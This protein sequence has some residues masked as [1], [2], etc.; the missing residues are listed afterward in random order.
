MSSPSKS[1]SN[2]ITT[3]GSKYVPPHL[4]KTQ[5]SGASNTN[6][7]NSNPEEA[8]PSYSRNYS[9]SSSFGSG[10]GGN[11]GG[12]GYDRN[13]QDNRSSI[14]SN[15]TAS[16]RWN[17]DAPDHTRSNGAPPT[18]SFS[19][20]RG[21]SNAAHTNARGFHGDMSPDKRLEQRLFS[22]KDHQT[23]GINFDNYDK[24]PCEISG[25]NVP[26][27]IEVY[28]TET[29]GDDLFRNTQLCHYSRPTPVQKYSIPIGQQGRD[30][31]ACAQT[32]SGVSTTLWFLYSFH[33][34]SDRFL[35]LLLD[36]FPH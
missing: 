7:N 6:N 19:S 34:S 21:M 28:T 35:L 32:G 30:L 18:S 13:Y 8:R 9:S 17:V 1:Q 27:P 29:I 10:R 2:T 36:T 4:R 5:G 24:I 16:S 33:I 22:Q 25:E 31:M 23:T 12:G 20:S 15:N 14:S 11:R 3:T 26:D